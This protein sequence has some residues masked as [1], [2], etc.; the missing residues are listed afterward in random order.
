MIRIL[1]TALLAL[2]LTA[3]GAFATSEDDLIYTDGL[4]YKKFT[5]VPFTGEVDDGQHRGAFKNGTREGPW[6]G[7]WSNGRVE[8]KGAFK[9]G[10]REGP[11]A[12]Y[13]DYG[14]LSEKGAFK[15][16]T[17]EGP[18]VGYWSN[19]RVEFKGAFKNG[20]REGPWVRYS[21]IGPLWLKGAFKNGQRE[22]PWLWYNEDD[23]KDENL[24]GVYRNDVKVSD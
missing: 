20:Q 14:Q 7:Y 24:S 3:S 22:G 17:R 16:G 10:T 12:N 23:T 4:A 6:V 1:T 11:W 13:D 15:N 8:F 2:S 19:G 9:N 21:I 5:D 18:W